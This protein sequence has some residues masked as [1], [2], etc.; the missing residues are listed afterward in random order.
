MK[1]CCRKMGLF[2]VSVVAMGAAA[3]QEKDV[4]TIVGRALVMSP[5]AADLRRLTDEVGGRVSGTPAMAR[6]IDWATAAFRSV[7]VETH[8]EHYRMPLTWSEG[9]THLE[10]LGGSAF[11]VSLVSEGWSS[12]TPAG[13]IEAELVHIGDGTEADFSRAAGRTR[14]AILLV[15]AQVIQTW[16]DLDNEYNRA[17]PIKQRAVEAG[18]RAVLW[19]S[20][21]DHRLLYRHTDTVDGELSPLPMATVAREDAMRLA[22]LVD[23]KSAPVRVRLSMPNVVGGPAEERNVIGEIRGKE[24]SSDFVVLGAHLDSWDLGTGALDNGCNAALV[25]A[26]AR[27][28]QSSGVRPRHTIRFVLFSGEEVGFQGSRAYVQQHRSELDHLRAMVVVDDGGGRITGFSL[29]G[30][31]DARESLQD[32]LEPLSNLDVGQLSLAGGLGTD[33]VDFML[34]GVPTLVADQEPATY[35]QNY[36]AASDTYDKVDLH[37][38]AQNTAAIAAVVYEIA[39]RAQPLGGR[40]SRAQITTLLESTGLDKEMKAQ[41]LWSAWESGKRGREK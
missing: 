35:M 7:G 14:G 26:V 38:I 3:A 24:N 15:D 39:D 20:A 1:A 22:R 29:S 11:P 5:L 4:S 25:I 6:A 10:I 19:T 34:E 17:L 41:G 16:E 37:Q 18:A 30:R 9:T 36:H 40:L 21:R 2:L 32:L 13:G 23:A 8:T 31:R 33:N 12:P 28:I 27:A